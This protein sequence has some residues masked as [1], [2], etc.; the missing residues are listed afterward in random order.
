MRLD[1]YLKVSRLIKRRSV[2]KEVAD[3]GRVKINGGVAKS[4][5]NVKVGDEITIQFGNKIVTVRVEALMDS[6]KKEDAKEMFSL[7]N[8]EQIVE[9]G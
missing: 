4:S 3:K 2:A 1:K 7:L 6:T 8:T 5:A 9:E